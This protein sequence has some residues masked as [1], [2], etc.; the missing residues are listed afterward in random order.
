EGEKIMY[1]H[2]YFIEMLARLYNGIDKVPLGTDPK[3]T[4]MKVLKCL[5]ALEKSDI[6]LGFKLNIVEW[7]RKLGFDNSWNIMKDFI[8]SSAWLARFS[9][10]TKLIYAGE[11]L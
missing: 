9:F 5:E 4:L 10:L 1:I 7:L 3:E 2:P 8:M 11:F 6:S